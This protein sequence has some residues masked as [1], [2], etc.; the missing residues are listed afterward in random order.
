MSSY[1]PT[2]PT[3]SPLVGLSWVVSR[4]LMKSRPSGAYFAVWRSPVRAAGSSRGSL[5]VR[6]GEIRRD[7]RVGPRLEQRLGFRIRKPFGASRRSRERQ[8]LPVFGQQ[9][10]LVPASLG[11]DVIAEAQQERL[12]A[13]A[14]RPPQN[15]DARDSEFAISRR[16]M[17]QESRHNKHNDPGQSGHKPP[18]ANPVETPEGEGRRG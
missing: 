17:N 16:G 8:E 11:H 13:S 9:G 18:R 10:P 14:T 7:V 1:V 4:K 5:Q 6:P 2:Q 3:Q 12:A 15:P